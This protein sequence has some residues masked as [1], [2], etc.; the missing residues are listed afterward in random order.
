MLLLFSYL[1]INAQTALKIEYKQTFL[2]GPIGS[3]K[4]DE[5]GNKI[6]KEVGVSKIR[7]IIND[8]FGIVYHFGNNYD[9]FKHKKIIGDKL[10]HHTTFLDFTNLEY[11]EESNFPKGN[12]FLILC[13]DSVIQKWEITEDVKY[14]LGNKCN[15][16]LSVD[17]NNDSTL[18]WFTS[19]LKFKKGF[20]FYQ[21]I[22]GVVLEASTQKRGGIKYIA[23]K[24]EEI[25]LKIIRPTEGVKIT[26]NDYLALKKK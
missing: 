17:E 9:P 7:M 20:L 25:D 5:N 11:Y 12:K 8:S 26:Y 1:K 21:A 13:N 6:L 22:P 3:I 23:T 16:A 15:A 4:L 19:E 10:V 14:I 2:D 24:I 18:V